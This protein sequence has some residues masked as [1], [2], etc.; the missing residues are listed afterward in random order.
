MSQSF[1]S[2]DPGDISSSSLAIDWGSWVSGYTVLGTLDTVILVVVLVRFVHLLVLS[3]RMKR[4]GTSDGTI[5]ADIA[6]KAVFFGSVTAAAASGVV[7]YFCLV[8]TSR[9]HILYEQGD[10]SSDTIVFTKFLAELL[11]LLMDVCVLVLWMKLVT[12][13]HRTQHRGRGDEDDAR[14]APGNACLRCCCRA[15]VA[16]SAAATAACYVVMGAAAAVWLC[17][18]ALWAWG[19]RAV[20]PATALGAMTVVLSTCFVLCGAALLAAGVLLT[21]L[22]WQTQLREQA[23]Q[24]AMI[25]ALALPAAALLVAR[26]AVG[27]GHRL[28]GYTRYRHSAWTFVGTALAVETLPTLLLVVLM[29][30]LS[31]RADDESHRLLDSTDGGRTPARGSDTGL[32]PD[33]PSTFSES[34]GYLPSTRENLGAAL[35]RYHRGAHVSKVS[36]S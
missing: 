8:A 3:W 21:C 2:E 30:P 12:L 17:C 10:P 20:A 11:S 18:T 6:P 26:G 31:Q 14:L 7:N 25:P 24:R 34:G 13:F 28:R 16:L 32:L 1:P 23:T 19:A 35:D 29:W 15:P 27:L 5:S 4:G 9:R 36:S 33:A 22:L